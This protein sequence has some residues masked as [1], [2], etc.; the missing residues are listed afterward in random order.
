MIKREPRRLGTEHVR[1][2][3]LIADAADVVTMVNS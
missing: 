3:A 2:I 1:S